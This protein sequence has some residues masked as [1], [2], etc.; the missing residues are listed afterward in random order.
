[1]KI[2]DDQLLNTKNSFN[3][4]N[5]EIS[6]DLIWYDHVELAVAAGKS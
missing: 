4:V 3:L 5:V 2:L 1:M 6:N